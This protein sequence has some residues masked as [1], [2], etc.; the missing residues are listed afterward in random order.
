MKM[1]FFAAS[2]AIALLTACSPS[3]ETKQNETAL[4]SSS[5]TEVAAQSPELGDFGLDL[6]TMDQTVQPGDDFFR[7]VNGKWLDSFEIPADRTSYGSFTVLADRSEK[8]VRQII[9]NAAKADA[10]MGSS[11]Q[12]IGDLYASFLD[13]GTIEERGLSGLQPDLDAIA[14]A[15][16]HVQIAEIMSRPDLPSRGPF[17][18]FVNVDS[19][20]PTAY[21][22]YLSHSGLGMPSRDYYL[23]KDE[24]SVA[25]QAGYQ[26]HIANMLNLAN[27]ENAE[28]KAA[29]IMALET[30]IAEAQWDRQDRRNRD[31]T[32]NKMTME[33][34]VK[35]AP[36]YPWQAANEAA[37]L[38]VNEVVVREKSAFPKIAKIFAETS[39]DDWKAYLTFHV[40][41]SNAAS[42]PKAF[43][44][45]NFAFFGTQLYG[46]PQQR[47]RWK[48][49]VA[50]VN[51]S[52][53]EA[54]GQIYV[55][56]YFPPESKRK[57]DELVENVRKALGQRI[58]GLEWMSDETK[59]EARAKLAAFTP[60]IGYPDKWKDYSSLQIDRLDLL[61]NTR[62][63][64]VWAWNEQ[65]SKLGGPIDKS[66]WFMSP[67]TVNAYYS[68]GRN[69]I[70]FPAAIL[71]APFFDP[72]ADPAVNYG[73]IGAVIG[74]EMGHG[75]D[76]QGSKSDGTG[77]LRNWWTAEDKVAFD[78]R[79]GEL[80]KQYDEFSPLE[81]YTVNGKATMGENIG[82]LGGLTFAIN[83]YHL[84]LD[85]KPAPV[86]DGLTGDQ[87]LFMAWAQ[88]W[89]GKYRD[90]ALINRLKTAP[91]SPTEFR[92]N[93][94][95][96]NMDAWY[97]AFDVKPG[98]AL[99]LPPEQRV[100][101]W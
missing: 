17:G 69:E 93:G 54:V 19:K 24:R 52:L 18:G 62:A 6:D 74:H 43:D 101:I 98:D 95:V 57:M 40:L 37:G 92:T 61:G 26:A 23:D 85:G 80:G 27:V 78:A 94:V 55:G 47:D 21:A 64:G 63:A 4:E 41:S 59:V 33:E 36:G 70:V 75:F 39:L 96:R 89:R 66:E 77:Q 7:Y 79:T 76:D 49:G 25:L 42:L 1:R 9:Q 48:R 97:E 38:S 71:Q 14:A 53:G 56:L 31:L 16:D 30:K 12:K 8:Q 22:F 28:E 68:P 91:H 86:I 32:Y 46:Q 44:D 58:D 87:R 5:E 90:E 67:Q 11:E 88:V 35:F 81:G 13:T 99:Y 72:N 2:A 60:K 50:L 84:S 10:S 45:E 3:V 15:S 29:A 100:R 20:V 83:A 65:K 34:L 73:G 82:D 51:R